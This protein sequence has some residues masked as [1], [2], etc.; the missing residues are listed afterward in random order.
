LYV[1]V[2]CTSLRRG[3]E[4]TLSKREES[5]TH[6]KN[7]SVTFWIH[8]FKP[9]NGEVVTEFTD[10]RTQEAAILHRLVDSHPDKRI[11]FIFN[12]HDLAFL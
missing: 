7:L 6:Y 2:A 8:G 5:S 11:L 12:C 9:E 1:L 3:S 4:E 10:F